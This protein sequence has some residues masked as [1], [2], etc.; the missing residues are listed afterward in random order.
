MEKLRDEIRG[1]EMLIIDLLLEEER[2]MEEIDRLVE[3]VRVLRAEL[4]RQEDELLDRALG[5]SV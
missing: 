2:D 3:R 5:K 4:R 1:Y